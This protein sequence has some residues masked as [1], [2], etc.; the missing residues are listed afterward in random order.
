MKEKIKNFWEKNKGEVVRILYYGLG[1]GFGY[2]AA[3]QITE[4]KI[5]RGLDKCI[6]A[7]PELESLLM[8]AIE[9]LKTE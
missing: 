2:F 5:S 3:S 1:F 8:E 9:T 7:K 4:L 6:L